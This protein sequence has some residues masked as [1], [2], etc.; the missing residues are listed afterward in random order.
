MATSPKKTGTAE[1]LFG[2]AHQM[3]LQP[4][5]IIPDGLF[6]IT[7][8]SAEQYINL[9]CSPLNSQAGA[10]LAKDKYLTRLVLERHRLPNIPF[11]LPQT[12]QQA[13]HFL[14]THKKI[15]AKPV[16]GAGA[17]D[18]HIVTRPSQLMSL[19][20]TDYILE[21]YV[22]GKEMR[23]LVLNG[24]IIGVHQSDYGT[25]VEETRPLARISYPKT[26]WDDDLMRMSLRVARI[27]GLKFAAVDYLIDAKGQAHILEVNT[28]PGLKWFH[29]PT[30]GPVVDV[31]RLFLEAIV[32]EDNLSRHKG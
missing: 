19:A 29:A 3:G 20:I 16:C 17:H 25:S 8:G 30:S 4:S 15:I 18:I 27:L 24:E 7:R 9:A 32:R 13:T 21:Q 5:W 12:M 10:S 6:A 14:R 22:A 31:A 11:I 28:T 2:R 26:T 23:Y 1:L